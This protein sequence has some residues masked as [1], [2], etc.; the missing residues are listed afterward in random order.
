MTTA[1]FA[2]DAR[3]RTMTPLCD[4]V[5]EGL[6]SDCMIQAEVARGLG[7]GG[8][9]AWGGSQLRLVWILVVSADPTTGVARAQRLARTCPNPHATAC[10]ER[11]GD[12]SAAI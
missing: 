6:L 4:R 1:H 5:L 2:V 10:A 12:T 3:R 8:D 9:R 11:R 7:A